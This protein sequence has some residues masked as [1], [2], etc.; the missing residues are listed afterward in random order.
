MMYH[1]RFDTPLCE[2]ILAGNEEGL[3]HLHL[4]TGEG[5]RHFE[6]AR[7][8]IHNDVFF[9]DAIKQIK[10]YFDGKRREFDVAVNPQGTDFQKSVWRELFAIPYGELRTYK[11]IAKAIGNE[12]AARAVGM[13]NSKNPIPLIVPCHRV[14]GANGKLT[15]FAHGL[16][17][18]ER[19]INFEQ[20]ALS[21]DYKKRN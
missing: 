19:L 2:V 17:I 5:K 12:K 14:I 10:A 16:A 20:K 21:I 9:A 15:G 3:T 13:A 6:I 7:K 8:W 4:N 18:K 1:T 11:D